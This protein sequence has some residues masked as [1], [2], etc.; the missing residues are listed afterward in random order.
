MLLLSDES[1]IEEEGIV[2]HL[3]LLKMN[4]SARPRDRRDLS[5]TNLLETY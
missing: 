2:N 4:D 1:G 5:S 3:Q